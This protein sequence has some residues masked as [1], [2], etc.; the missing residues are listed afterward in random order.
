M[1]R[2][3][4]YSLSCFLFTSCAIVDKMYESA[5]TGVSM[6]AVAITVILI[7]YFLGRV[8]KKSK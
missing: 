5:G 7:I 6:I 4:F 3:L 1:N 2:L 8:K